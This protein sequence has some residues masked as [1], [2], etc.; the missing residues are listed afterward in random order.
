MATDAKPRKQ[1]TTDAGVERVKGH[2]VGLG[3]GAGGKGKEGNCGKGEIREAAVEKPTGLGPKSIN[4][5]AISRARA[6]HM[7]RNF[8]NREARFFAIRRS[9]S[10]QLA[11][12]ETRVKSIRIGRRCSYEIVAW[13]GRGV[14]VRVSRLRVGLR[15]ARPSS[16]EE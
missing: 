1:D 9:G 11:T 15:S 14:A 3:A 10:A 12:D 5:G 6:A 7:T 4:P 8:Q 13:R 2:W 16:V